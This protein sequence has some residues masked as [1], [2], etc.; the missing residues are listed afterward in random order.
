MAVIVEPAPGTVSMTS[1]TS[2]LKDGAE[3]VRELAAILGD[4]AG[5]VLAFVAPGYDLDRVGA[6]LH[7]WCGD[8]V[9][10]C[11]SAGNI[12]PDGYQDEGI[13]AVA[14]SGGGL[15]AGTVRIDAGIDV[16]DAVCQV[17]PQ[18]VG[19]RSL[20]EIGDVFGILLVD[21]LAAQQDRLAATLRSLLGDVPIVGG[22]AGDDLSFSR[23]AVY[24]DGRF[25]PNTATFT[26]VATRAPFRIVRLQHHE[27]TDTMLVVTEAVPEERLVGEINGRPAVE[28]YAEAVGVSVAGLDPSVFSAHPMLLHAAGEHW[29][30]SVAAIGPEGSLRLFA[31]VDRGDVLRLGRPSGLLD[32]LERRLAALGSGGD[33]GVLAFD[34]VLR[35]IEAR[36]TGVEKDVNSCLSRHGVVGLSTYGE[37]FNGMNVNHTM[38]AVAFAGACPPEPEPPGVR[39]VDRD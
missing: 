28:A 31:A 12:G 22:S 10:A 1:A 36:A 13:V 39:H 14:L 38:A 33:G 11:T 27:P 20:R 5:L 25:R 9:A 15:S 29:I 8:R 35:R 2:F 6:E 26:V 23:T 30:R 4:S 17:G 32:D 37:Q 3:A 16:V 7:R 18:L 24:A 19:L 34:C 21:G